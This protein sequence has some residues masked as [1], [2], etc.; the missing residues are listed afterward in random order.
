MKVL[1]KNKKL[2]VNILTALI[3]FQVIFLLMQFL[4][5]GKLSSSVTNGVSDDSSIFPFLFFFVFIPPIL[6]SKKNKLS[7][8]KKVLLMWGL[9]ILAT[10]VLSLMVV[11]LAKAW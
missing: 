9:V 3:V 11:V 1:L 4:V 5:F 10:V 6:L 7:E 8:E 2:A